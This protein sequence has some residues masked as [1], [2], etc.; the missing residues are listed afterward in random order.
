MKRIALA[1]AAV[2]TL[3]ACQQMT[4]EPTAATNLSIRTLVS[5]PPPPP[6]DS[7][8]V[9]YSGSTNTN[10]FLNVTYFFNKTA[11]SGWLKF[12]SEAG[13]ATVDKN[14]Q[15]RFSSGQFSGKGI[16]TVGNVTIDLSRVSQSSRFASCAAWGTVVAGDAATTSDTA[17]VGC[18]NLVIGNAD[19][20]STYLTEKC[21]ISK[22]AYDPRAVCHTRI[23]TA[24]E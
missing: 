23:D 1:V 12:D 5:N 18:F 7:G 21:P 13:D 6:I 16:I 14:A 15:V 8:S 11:N 10:F 4:T 19:G 9:G 24:G 20:T 17:P 22:D 2:V 3:A